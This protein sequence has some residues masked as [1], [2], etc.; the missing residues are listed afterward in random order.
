[1]ATAIKM[2]DFGTTVEQVKVVRW[3]KQVGDPVKKGEPLCEVETD[4]ATV[5]LESVAEGVLL[6]QVVPA[7]T[8]LQ[9][10]TVMAFIGQPGEVVPMTQTQTPAPMVSATVPL[11]E[12]PKPAAAPVGAIKASPMVRHLAQREGVDIHTV[13][14]TGPSGQITRDD[15]LRAK[16]LFASTPQAASSSAAGQAVAP[17]P[18]SAGLSSNQRAVARRVSQSHR[19]IVPINLVGRIGMSAALALRQRMAQQGRKISFDAVLVYA[20][21]RVIAQFPRFR[22]GMAGE[23]VTIAPGIHVGFAAGMAEELFTPT[24][25]DADHLTLEQ[26][27]LQVQRLVTK[28]REGHLTLAEMSGACFT[29]SNLGMYPVQSF[30]VV[31]PPGQTAALAVGTIEEV[32]LLRDGHQSSQP[33]AAVTLSVDHRLINGRQGAEFLAALKQF[34]ERL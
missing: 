11:A 34:V 10:G 7:G 22:L 27:E 29:V 31:I 33:M 32:I 2:P 28:A 6:A 9:E 16:A 30:N 12:R 20:I 17:A 15:I 26:I 4:K 21:S 18:A 14:G 3:L 23:E 24:I 1:M 8:E 5:D 19:E 13:Q 25:A